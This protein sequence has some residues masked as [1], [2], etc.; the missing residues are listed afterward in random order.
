MTGYDRFEYNLRAI[1]EMIIAAFSAR[2]L[3]ALVAYD[4]ELG[5]LRHEF[6]PGDAIIEMADKTID[7]CLRRLV[8]EHFLSLVAE[9]RPAQYERFEDKLRDTPDRS[10]V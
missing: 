6:S 9:E 10:P 1:R 5:P 3:R 2:E 4:Q 7:Y 8:L